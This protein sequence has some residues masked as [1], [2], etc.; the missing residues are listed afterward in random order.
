MPV[1]L[2]YGDNNLEIDEAVRA[3]RTTFPSTDALVLDGASVSLPDLSEACLTAGLFDPDRLVVVRGLHERMKGNRKDSELEEIKR[4]LGSIPP[5]TTVILSSP[6]MPAEHVLVGAVREVGG[7]VKPAMIPKRADLPRWIIQRVK[8]HDASIDAD[9]AELL[10][11]LAGANPVLLE[12]EI[13]KLATYAGR[14]ERITV[15]AVETLVGAVPQDTIFTLVD[16]IA[17]G[18]RGQALQLLHAQVAQASSSPIDFALYLIRMLAR[19]VRILLRIHLGQERGRSTSQITSELKIPRY[20]A[21]RYL[22]QARRLSKDRLIAAIEQLAA[23]EHGLKSG[24]TDAATGLDIL[25][26]DL[27]S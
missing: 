9:A 6:G 13:E 2:L 18:N 17:A 21:D 1:Q 22:R 23:L 10:A 24:T 20:Y 15:E 3:I 16:E 27:C 26:A 4:L 11:D 14:G 8:A 25:V 19:Q 12:T 7:A 5:T